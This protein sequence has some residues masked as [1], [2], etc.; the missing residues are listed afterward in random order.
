[1]LYKI[2]N[3]F[4]KK[5]NE[6]SAKNNKLLW[7]KKNRE[8]DFEYRK[9]S[10]LSKKITNSGNV[11]LE[12]ISLW[13]FDK[14]ELNSGGQGNALPKLEKFLEAFENVILNNK[15]KQGFNKAN[16]LQKTGEKM[17]IDAIIVLSNQLNYPDQL[18]A[19]LKR[20]KDKRYFIFSDMILEPSLEKTLNII[21]IVKE[22]LEVSAKYKKAW[23]GN[24]IS[25]FNNVYFQWIIMSVFLLMTLPYMVISKEMIKTEAFMKKR[26]EWEAYLSS[27]FIGFSYPSVSVKVSF[28]LQNIVIWLTLAWIIL[29]FSK[30]LFYYFEEKRT[31][32]IDKIMNELAFVYFIKIQI[33]LIVLWKIKTLKWEVKNH[34]KNV[35]YIEFL[36][37][38]NNK[39]FSK[40]LIWYEFNK[41]LSK[42]YMIFKSTKKILQNW[43][44]SEFFYNQMDMILT[45][46][47]NFI[48]WTD[49]NFNMDKIQ[50][51]LTETEKTLKVIF[52]NYQKKIVALMWG[53]I[54]LFIL[55]FVLLASLYQFQQTDNLTKAMKYQMRNTQ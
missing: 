17:N 39:A 5:D 35:E 21:K 11:K 13:F 15:S 6:G 38:G 20:Q 42:L 46:Y 54:M 23:Q 48:S 14:F 43:A 27:L 44:W 22:Y 33:E 45:W 40:W 16:A 3:I 32:A 10:S 50:K 26:P 9:A 28:L 12:D 51:L 52:D 2:K 18:N 7:N 4:W 19:T 41:E 47:K 55:V 29:F 34:Y 37:Q 1:M 36:V 49:V 53:I 31:R 24:A 25:I 8:D 30:A